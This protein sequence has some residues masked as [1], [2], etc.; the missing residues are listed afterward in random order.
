ML[1]LTPQKK[2]QSLNATELDARLEDDQRLKDAIIV[3]CT[4]I[5]M[6]L[7]G[8]YFDLFERWHHFVRDHENL[9]LDEL[10]I[11]VCSLAVMLIWYSLRRQ[12]QANALKSLA[13][14][15]KNDAYAKSEAKSEFLANMSHELRTPL[16]AIIGYSEAM[17]AGVFG[18]VSNA[19]QEDCLHDVHNSGH[20]LLNLINDILDISKIEAKKEKL[21][22]R[23]IE[24]SNMMDI[25]SRRVGILAEKKNI[26]L[27]V[28]APTN[29]PMLLGD[30]RRVVQVFINLLSNAIKFTPEGGEVMFSAEICDDGC[31]VLRVSD[32]GRGISKKD[33]DSIFLPFEQAG[34]HLMG[35]QVGTGLG[36]TL[37]TSLMQ[38]HGGDFAI[39][40]E[41]GTGTTVTVRFPAERTVIAS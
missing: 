21:I 20:H 32:T 25:S 10:T 28:D 19:K 17:M 3:V 23:T 1:N 33:L 6:T 9:E 40:S 11:G 4:S 2:S 29:A 16:N 41:L 37:C 14:Q 34:D 39:D 31:H 12:R 13:L 36:L 5:G 27:S 30:E 26:T 15:L 38:L 7:I 35:A 22:E 24:V 18:K 8:G